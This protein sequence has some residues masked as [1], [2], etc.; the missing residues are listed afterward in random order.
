M[1]R[2]WTVTVNGKSVDVQELP[3]REIAR[4]AKANDRSW[5]DVVATPLADLN[6]ALD[7]LA[8]AAKQLGE[9][10]SESITSK[11]I[12]ALFDIVEREDKD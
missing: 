8:V 3:A 1:E 6:V 9:D 7:L 4:I 5:F 12:V 10:V 11:E 2:A